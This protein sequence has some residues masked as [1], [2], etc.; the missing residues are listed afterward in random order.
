MS[1]SNEMP[2]TG[3]Q[4][5]FD[6]MRF[7]NNELESAIERTRRMY[8]ERAVAL[9]MKEM[10][11]RTFTSDQRSFLGG[12][13]VSLLTHM[14]QFE[15]IQMLNRAAHIPEEPGGE[16]YELDEEPRTFTAEAGERI[17]HV[18]GGGHTCLKI[19]RARTICC[20]Q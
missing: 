9:V 3:V 13:A 7:L 15:T 2:A 19:V 18:V 17:E 5:F 16:T 1:S 20:I 4:L 10:G 8:G 12:V 14:P 11:G 6:G